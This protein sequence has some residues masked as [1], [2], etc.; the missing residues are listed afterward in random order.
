M[1]RDWQTDGHEGNHRRFSRE[2]DVPKK[3]NLHDL[4]MS[5]GI[6]VLPFAA[7]LAR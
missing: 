2:Y 5:E 7:K 6:F 1:Q 4:W 3:G